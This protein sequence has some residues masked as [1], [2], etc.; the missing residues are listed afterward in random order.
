MV[1]NMPVLGYD[2]EKGVVKLNDIVAVCKDC[3][4]VIH[5]GRT[6]LKG[7]EE[8]AEKHFMKVNKCNYAEYRKA[9]GDA[10]EEH[11]KNNA[12]SEWIMDVSYL[13]RYL[14]D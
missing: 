6:Q 11:I 12:V 1:E 3:H 2:R 10:N 4:S 9:L 8:R 7:D 13:K 5:I 14:K